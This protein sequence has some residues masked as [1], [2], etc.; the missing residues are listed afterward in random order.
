MV[1]PSNVSYCVLPFTAP[2]N[3][4]EALERLRASYK[5]LLGQQ[6]LT[7]ADH[8]VQTAVEITLK[9]VRNAQRP[10]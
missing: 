1:P 9:H 8:A 7:E 4:I 2:Q 5:G 6:A 3:A 10:A